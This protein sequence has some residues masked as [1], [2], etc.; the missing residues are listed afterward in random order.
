MR[1]LVAME[2]DA[3]RFEMR[4][5][6]MLFPFIS[7]SSQNLEV[8]YQLPRVTQALRSVQNLCVIL[9]DVSRTIILTY[10]FGLADDNRLCGLCQKEGIARSCIEGARKKGPFL[11]YSPCAA[12]MVLVKSPRPRFIKTSRE[13]V[14][15]EE[16]HVR[17]SPS[18]DYGHGPSARYEGE[19]RLRILGSSEITHPTSI[20]KLQYGY[21][22]V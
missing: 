10:Q 4:I 8:L 5:V 7:C 11:H 14:N 18:H 2:T 21:P 17:S 13:A 6:N 1:P 15:N 19:S 3:E 12:S 20:T 22:Y 9:P 16:V